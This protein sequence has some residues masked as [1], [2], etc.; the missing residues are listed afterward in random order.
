MTSWADISVDKICFVQNSSDWSLPV[1]QI[2]KSFSRSSSFTTP[3][4]KFQSLPLSNATPNGLRHSL[5]ST[6]ITFAT[7]SSDYMISEFLRGLYDSC[8]D[9]SPV[10]FINLLKLFS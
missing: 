3:E 1:C 6:S 4:L 5:L 2:F 8:E 10:K 9:K 7:F